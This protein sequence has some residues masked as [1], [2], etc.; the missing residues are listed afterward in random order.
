M[1][2]INYLS[3]GAALCIPALAIAAL[4]LPFTF[5]EGDTLSA[6]EMNAKFQ[7]LADE[8][9]TLKTNGPVGFVITADTTLNIPGVYASLPEALAYLDGYAIASAKNRC[10]KAESSGA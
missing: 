5:A 2:L 9:E 3:V 7:A 10:Q 4:D 1:K 8:V 6:A